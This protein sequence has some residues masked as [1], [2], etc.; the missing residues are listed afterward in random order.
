MMIKLVKGMSIFT[1]FFFLIPQTF[2]HIYILSAS[3]TILLRKHSAPV[4]IFRDIL[5]Q[6]MNAL[7]YQWISVVSNARL[8]KCSLQVNIIKM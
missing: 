2:W 3:L 8:E 5:N 1:G 4:E 6:C 7:E